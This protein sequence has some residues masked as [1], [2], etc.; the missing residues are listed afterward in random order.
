M[1]IQAINEFRNQN[2]K[3]NVFAWNPVE[4]DHCFL[5]C[6]H[7]A[8]ENRVIHTPWY[9]LNGKAEAVAMSYFIHN[10][11]DTIR[12]LIFQDFGNSEQHR[13]V[14]LN[15]DN[16]AYGFFMFDW[17]AYLTIRGWN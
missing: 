15:Y 14:F 11:E 7:M 2:G 13:N 5:H 3:G 16:L 9:F 17:K 6:L 12:S 8:K 1:V 4:N 10:A